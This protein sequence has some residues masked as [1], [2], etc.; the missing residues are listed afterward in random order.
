MIFRRDLYTCSLPD[1]LPLLALA[2]FADETSQM[3]AIAIVA[4]ELGTQI[5]P[6]ERRGEIKF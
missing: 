3:S 2:I 1:L 5:L 4:S 6:L